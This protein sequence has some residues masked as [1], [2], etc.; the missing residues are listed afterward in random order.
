[1]LFNTYK[2]PY[3][4]MLSIKG[5]LRNGHNSGGGGGLQNCSCKREDLSN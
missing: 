3:A 4:R 1:M 5:G 2:I